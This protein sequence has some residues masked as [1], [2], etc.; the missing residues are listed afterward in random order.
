[1]SIKQVFRHTFHNSSIKIK[2]NMQNLKFQGLVN[3]IFIKTY[4]NLKD[5]NLQSAL[6]KPETQH[7]NIYHYCDQSHFQVYCEKRF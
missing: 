2:R 4:I 1:M 5:I 6:E 3:R 7:A